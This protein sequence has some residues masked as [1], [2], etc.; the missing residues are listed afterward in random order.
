MKKDKKFAFMEDI[1]H[2][3]DKADFTAEN[4]AAIPCR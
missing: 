3:Y 1:E 2:E 4:A